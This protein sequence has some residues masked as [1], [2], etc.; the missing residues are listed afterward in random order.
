MMACLWPAWPLSSQAQRS[1]SRA[2]SGESNLNSPGPDGHDAVCQCQAGLSHGHG[3]TAAPGGQPWHA[4][5]HGSGPGSLGLSRAAALRRTRS[6]PQSS[7]SDS[8]SAPG[9]QDSVRVVPP[10]G[11]CRKWWNLEPPLRRIEVRRNATAQN[12]PITNGSSHPRRLGR[13]EGPGL[14]RSGSLTEPGR[15]SPAWPGQRNSPGS[16][17]PARP[18]TRLPRGPSGS[19]AT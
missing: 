15:L 6:P 13:C 7:G 2:R 18:L 14:R 3:G 17:G 5:G 11:L 4:A 19:A 10:Q 9:R 12:A 1:P 8:E 16:P